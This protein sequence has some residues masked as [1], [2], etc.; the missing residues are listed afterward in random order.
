MDWFLS[1][2]ALVASTQAFILRANQWPD[3]LVEWCVSFNKTTSQGAWLLLASALYQ[4]LPFH[5][6][7]RLLNVLHHSIGDNGLVQLPA[8]PEATLVHCVQTA[9]ITGDWELMAQFPGI[10]WSVGAFVRRRKLPFDQWLVQTA[11]RDIWRACG[12]IHYM[13]KNSPI[14]PKVMAFLFRLFSPSP[15]G[16]GLTSLLQGKAPPLP[17][18]MGARRW[19][20]WVGPYSEFQYESA[21]PSQK[22]SIFQEVYHQLNPAEPWRACHGLQFFTEPLVK[23]YFCSQKMGACRQCPL[24]M[25]CPKVID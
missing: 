15:A 13:G 12:E 7:I 19:M 4:G 16:L 24:Y 2:P 3:P 5:A 11:P 10:V 21:S 1:K 22:V 23:G 6:L 20:A 17:V 25:E 14:R 9:G 8:T 18:T